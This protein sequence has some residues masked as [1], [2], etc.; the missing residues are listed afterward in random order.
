MIKKFM[1]T[2]LL[3]LTLSVGAVFASVKNMLNAYYFETENYP[4][5]GGNITIGIR[6]QAE[7]KWKDKKRK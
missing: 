7:G 1:L 6:V 4:M 2:M 3:M 5:P